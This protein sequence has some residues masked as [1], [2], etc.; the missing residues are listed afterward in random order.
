MVREKGF[1]SGGIAMTMILTRV[2]WEEG[3]GIWADV[4]W[5]FVWEDVH[6]WRGARGRDTSDLLRTMRFSSQ[7]ER[8]RRGKVRRDSM[9]E[10]EGE[11]RSM[12]TSLWVFGRE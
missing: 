10:H 3:G 6:V 1:R 11:R 2:G 4:E 7:M 8:E 12:T 5:E 9:E